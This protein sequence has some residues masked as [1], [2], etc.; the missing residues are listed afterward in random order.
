MSAH[1]LF[2]ALTWLA[3]T[4]LSHGFLGAEGFFYDLP[5]EQMPFG[6]FFVLYTIAFG[7]YLFVIIKTSTFPANKR[8][9]FIVL[10]GAFVFR[11]ILIPSVPVHENDIY[12][13]IWDG[14]VSV[15]G[16]NPYKHAPIG[17]S[18]KPAS[19]DQQND[20]QKLKSLRDENP[21][22]IDG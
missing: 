10:G 17:A 22:H 4:L 16:I 3:I 19:V 2:S 5:N 11:L 13:Y 14:K 1:V 20:Y 7:L 15:A 6:R 12:R 8:N 21:S 18:I 9:I